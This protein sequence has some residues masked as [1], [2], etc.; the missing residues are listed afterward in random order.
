MKGCGGPRACF[1]VRRA[2]LPPRTIGNGRPPSGSQPISPASLLSNQARTKSP[3][4]KPWMDFFRLCPTPLRFGPPVFLRTLVVLDSIST[5]RT[6]MEQPGEGRGDGW[7]RRPCHYG[8]AQSQAD[9]APVATG[10]RQ[11]HYSPNRR[12]L[13]GQGLISQWLLFSQIWYGLYPCP[14]QVT[15]NNS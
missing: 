9:P 5:P 8:T 1:C 12:S 4:Q 14:W 6:A 2:I 10:H 7:R 13:F 11:L 3:R 15:N